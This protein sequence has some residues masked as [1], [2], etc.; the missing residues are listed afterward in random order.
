MILLLVLF[1]NILFFNCL[2]LIYVV[3]LSLLFVV[4]ILVRLFVLGVDSIEY[5]FKILL[6]DI[7]RCV[8]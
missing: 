3:K 2:K 6:I 5:F 4:F 8:L 1:I 7:I